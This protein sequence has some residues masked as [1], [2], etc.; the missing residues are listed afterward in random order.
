MWDFSEF[1]TETLIDSAAQDAG[2]ALTLLSDNK[3]FMRKLT[4]PVGL[5]RDYQERLAR[6][7]QTN[8]KIVQYTIES[9]EEVGDEMSKRND[10]EAILAIHRMCEKILARVEKNSD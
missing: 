9:I 4:R 5:S 6:K 8:R 10:N 1:K 7:I 3:R 2:Y